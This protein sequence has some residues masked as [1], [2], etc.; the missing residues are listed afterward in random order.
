MLGTLGTHVL[1]Q[2]M[3]YVLCRRVS[4]SLT[5]FTAPEIGLMIDR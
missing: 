1:I 4:I 2:T 3:T 5:A